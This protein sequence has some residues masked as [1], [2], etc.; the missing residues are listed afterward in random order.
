[1]Q[2][3]FKNHLKYND[4][5]PA[6]LPLFKRAQFSRQNGDQAWQPSCHLHPTALETQGDTADTITQSALNT[7]EGKQSPRRMILLSGG[8]K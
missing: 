6:L 2:S 8:K 5:T 3:L 7:S 4:P 1:M